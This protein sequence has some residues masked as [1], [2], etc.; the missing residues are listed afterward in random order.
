MH[1]SC[2]FWGEVHVCNFDS[3][4]SYCNIF[5]RDA[6]L[7]QLSVVILL[8]LMDPNVIFLHIFPNGMYCKWAH[9]GSATQE[10][11]TRQGRDCFRAVREELLT[12]ACTAYTCSLWNTCE[13]LRAVQRRGNKCKVTVTYCLILAQ[14]SCSTRELHFLSQ[15]VPSTS[16]I[17][18]SCQ[19]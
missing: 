9:A 17:D 10:D 3:I 11:F 5:R 4:Y 7:V 15:I 19:T 8:Y 2:F 12:V 13:L 1:F 14:A 16:G 18:L 6:L